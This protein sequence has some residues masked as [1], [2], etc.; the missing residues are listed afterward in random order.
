VTT[1]ASHHAAAAVAHHAAAA[2]SFDRCDTDGFVSQWAHSKL[3]A[4]EETKAEIAAAGGTAEFP[5]LFRRSDGVRMRAKLVSYYCQ[6]AYRTKWAWSFRDSEGRV[7]RSAPSI[8]DTRSKRGKLWK[9][10]YEVRQER[11][12][13]SAKLTGS[14][15]GLGGSVWVE[16]YRTDDGYPVGA[17]GVQ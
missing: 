2:E 9:L 10:G 17:E 1:T 7:D 8:P 3:A 15:T 16:V 12:P 11:A 5:G 14:G 4:L 13:A 6:F